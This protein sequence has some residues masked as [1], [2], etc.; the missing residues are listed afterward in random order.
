MAG[1]GPASDYSGGV[2]GAPSTPGY[3]PTG[4]RTAPAPATTV[5]GPRFNNATTVAAPAPLTPPAWNPAS[6]FSDPS[7]V[8]Y[9]ASLGLESET[10]VARLRAAQDAARRNAALGIA[11]VQA[12]GVD[13]RRQ[14]AGGMEARGLSFSGEREKALA[15]QR[16][17]QGRQEAGVTSNAGNAVSDL[18]YQ[19][20]QQNASAG[21]QGAQA[22]YDASSRSQA[23]AQGY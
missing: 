4:V 20:A 15:R 5:A 9:R 21:R 22:A 18:E 14:V 1:Y 10:A 6:I 11:D 3:S 7:Y 17:A 23:A 19:I 12:Q 8:A 16:A 2:T 13:Q